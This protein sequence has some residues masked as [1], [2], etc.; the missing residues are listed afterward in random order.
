MGI[1]NAGHGQNSGTFFLVEQIDAKIWARLISVLCKELFSLRPGTRA[2]NTSQAAIDS[3]QPDSDAGKSN[4]ALRALRLAVVATRIPDCGRKERSLRVRSSRC[5]TSRITIMDRSST[6]TSSSYSS[7]TSNQR[8]SANSPED[9]KRSSH[10]I[11][12]QS[13]TS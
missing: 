5:H 7:E 3:F 10:S 13:Q 9:H 8:N 11:Q 12:S 6:A 2:H 1:V 4:N